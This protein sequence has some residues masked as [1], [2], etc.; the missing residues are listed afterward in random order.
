MRRRDAPHVGI[1]VDVL[2][3]GG[4]QHTGGVVDV[5]LLGLA[6]SDR[7]GDERMRHGMRHRGLARRDHAVAATDRGRAAGIALGLLE[8]ADDRLV[9]PSGPGRGLPGVVVGLVALEPDRGVD[10]G[11]AA[12]DLADRRDDDTIVERLLRHRLVAPV[13]VGAEVAR[14][15]H[16]VEDFFLVEISAAAFDHQHA[17]LAA[18]RQ[19]MRHHA[20]R[21][22]GADDDV[23]VLGA[24]IGEL[25]RLVRLRLSGL[26]RH[27]ARQRSRHAGRDQQFH[28]APAVEPAAIRGV[29]HRVDGIARGRARL[30]AEIVVHGSPSPAAIVSA[31]A[32]AGML[33]PAARPHQ[34]EPDGQATTADDSRRLGQRNYTPLIG[35]VR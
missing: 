28:K 15:D 20:A 22:A 1:D 13:G 17:G 32:H 27:V 4:V 29:D 35:T 12:D 25:H 9:A 7:R 26:L 14:V 34:L 33:V 2:L 3:T 6:E 21:G 19:A 24:Q 30:V 16:R 5:H 18:L 23:V 11:A 8:I 31:A 10:A